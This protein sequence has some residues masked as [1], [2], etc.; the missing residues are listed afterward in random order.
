MFA[1]D[2]QPTECLPYKASLRRSAGY[3]FWVERGLNKVEGSQTVLA[4]RTGYPSLCNTVEKN[5]NN[6]LSSST[7]RTVFVSFE[8]V[9][10][11]SDS[12]LYRTGA[13]G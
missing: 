7:R 4:M 13:G 11:L 6:G 12:D 9:L 8:L 3:L 10:L 5:S 2:S 1:L